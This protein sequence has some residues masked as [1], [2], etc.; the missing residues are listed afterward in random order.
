[1]GG[2]TTGSSHTI[3]KDKGD[4]DAPTGQGHQAG[5][6]VSR[7]TYESQPDLFSEPSAIQ[8]LTSAALG[9]SIRKALGLHP[10]QTGPSIAS[11]GLDLQSGER[12]SV[13]DRFNP[14]T[15][16]ESFLDTTT[17]C[18]LNESVPSTPPSKSWL[19]LSKTS[20]CLR[21][22]TVLSDQSRRCSKCHTLATDVRLSL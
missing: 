12:V 9:D 22:P 18:C 2:G 15:T 21:K 4:F 13:A 5:R 14:M 16:S 20:G 11:K 7:Q 6:Y 8:Q 19:D 1:M 3:S 10:Q 17:V